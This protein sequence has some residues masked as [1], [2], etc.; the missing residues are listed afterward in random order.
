MFNWIKSNFKIQKWW[1]C[2]DFISQESMNSVLSAR[3]RHETA[4]ISEMKDIN[5][6]QQCCWRHTGCSLCYSNNDGLQSYLCSLSVK[7]HDNRPRHRAIVSDRVSSPQPSSRH[8]WSSESLYHKAIY[9]ATETQGMTQPFYAH[10]QCDCKFMNFRFAFLHT[11]KPTPLWPS[12]CS[13]I[14][15]C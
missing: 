9:S 15:K 5:I 13:K 6:R 2:I 10:S 8:R 12:L 11:S 1:F 14:S 4:Q 7:Y 3:D